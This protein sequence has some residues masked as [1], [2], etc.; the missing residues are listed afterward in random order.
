[1]KKGFQVQK[2]DL[3]VIGA[4][5]LLGGIVLL[6]AIDFLWGVLCLILSFT[7]FYQAHVRDKAGTGPNRRLGDW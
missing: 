7:C 1:M 5:L 3:L 2:S 6:L 4:F